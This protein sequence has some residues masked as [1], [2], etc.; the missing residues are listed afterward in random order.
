MLTAESVRDAKATAVADA[1]VAIEQTRM[2]ATRVKVRARLTSHL[3]ADGQWHTQ[4]NVHHLSKRHLKTSLKSTSTS[5]RLLQ[6]T[7]RRRRRSCRW[8]LLL[9]PPGRFCRFCSGWTVLDT[10]S[11][12]VK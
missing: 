9:S 7:Q 3:T 11:V 5:R 1:D 8:E 2:D 12:Y 6:N 4:A 10:L